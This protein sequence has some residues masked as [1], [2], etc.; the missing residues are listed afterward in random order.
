MILALHGLLDGPRAFNDL[1]FPIAAPRI[2]QNRTSLESRV[3]WL[4]QWVDHQ[5][6]DNLHLLG[7]SLGGAL[8]AELSER[9]S[10][11]S[12]LLLA[13]VGFGEIRLSGIF[14]GP[15]R[16]PLETGVPLALRLSPLVRGV[17][18]HL[19]TAGGEMPPYLLQE[20]SNDPGRALR[21][22]KREMTL[23]DNLRR[24]PFSNLSYRG[25]VSALWGERDHLVPH[26]QQHIEEV[27]PQTRLTILPETGHDPIREDPARVSRWIAAHLERCSVT[28]S[29]SSKTG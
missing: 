27:W 16:L 21:R 2:P 1:P 10:P 9:V 4:E 8:A 7:H 24:Q 22:A 14:R 23:V 28:D 25:P 5:G 12:I 29:S 11:Q 3:D 20:I 17:Y 19:F 13:P 6:L 15:L 26:R 18:R